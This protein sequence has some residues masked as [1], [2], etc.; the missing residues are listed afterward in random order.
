MPVRVPPWQGDPGRASSPS[1]G[2]RHGPTRLSPL[3]NALQ[4]EKRRLEARIAQLEEEL[5]EEQGNMEAMS[6]RV[7]KATQQ[8]SGQ[9]KSAQKAPRR[10]SPPWL[11]GKLLSHQGGRHE[12]LCSD[13][14]GV[15]NGARPR[16]RPMQRSTCLDLGRNQSCPGSG[17]T[18]QACC[19]LPGESQ[20]EE[21][22]EDPPS[23]SKGVWPAPA[24]CPLDALH[25]LALSTRG[26]S[27]QGPWGPAL[28]SQ[29]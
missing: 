24:Y 29:P 7:R 25:C 1:S 9:G 22:A 13:R 10:A 15:C 27:L 6:D 19:V 23:S 3:R 16:P 11:P 28:L 20:A 4:D 2:E 14:A 5:E 12:A 8:V 18:P 26:R 21:G 17:A